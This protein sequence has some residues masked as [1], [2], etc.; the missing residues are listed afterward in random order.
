[1]TI[2]ED[3]TPSPEKPKATFD[4]AAETKSS[5]A[6]AFV[7]PSITIQGPPESGKTVAAAT[8]SDFCPSA[9]ELPA[10]KVCHLDDILYLGIDTS[11]TSSLYAL[12]LNIPLTFDAN[13]WVGAGGY[14][15]QVNSTTGVSKL[16]PNRT[17]TD[18]INHMMRIAYSATKEGGIKAIILDSPSELNVLL[19]AQM[20]HKEETGCWT[21]KNGVLNEFAKWMWLKKA[22]STMYRFLASLGTTLVFCMHTKGESEININSSTAALQIAKKK[23]RSVYGSHNII[24]D[25]PPSIAPIYTNNVDML[26]T[27]DVEIA[28]GRNATEKRVLLP[29]GGKGFVGKC[30]WKQALNMEGEPPDLKYIIAKVRASRNADADTNNKKGKH[31]GE[32]LDLKYIVEKV[33]TDCNV[34]TDTNNKEGQNK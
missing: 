14:E 4:L 1:M 29:R 21:N 3:Q 11:G 25:I 23:A 12:N 31:R 16:V 15:E 28:P 19:E 34:D 13:E 24:P 10:D 8:I 2:V 27:M 30:R 18:L 32:P 22:H 33:R 17:A 5:D 7:S 6:R 20:I 26:A 9:N